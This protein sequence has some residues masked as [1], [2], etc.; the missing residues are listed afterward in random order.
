MITDIIDKQLLLP[1]M[2][3]TTREEL[4][5][6]F[7]LAISRR[8]PQLDAAIIES[9]FC[10]RES[11]GSTAMGY[12]V[13]LPHGRT[14]LLQQFVLSVGISTAPIDF[15]ASDGIPCRIF[16]ALLSP[17]GMAAQHLFL[18]SQIARRAKHPSFRSWLLMAKSPEQVYDT[19]I[20]S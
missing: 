2:A 7:S 17:E 18:L 20:S 12:G 16:F 19:L 4:L 9:V 1:N 13:A 11:L 15:G 14:P 8:H 5:K 6:E 10:E 3:A